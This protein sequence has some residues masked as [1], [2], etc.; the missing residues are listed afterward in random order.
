MRRRSSV[1]KERRG[2]LM[3]KISMVRGEETEVGDFVRIKRYRARLAAE[4][5]EACKAVRWSNAIKGIG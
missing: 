4:R 1:E 5:R 3:I 2:P